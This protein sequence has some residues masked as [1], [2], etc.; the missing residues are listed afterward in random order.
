MLLLLLLLLIELPSSTIA[1]APAVAADQSTAAVAADCFKI[2]NMK[3][4]TFN[5]RRPMLLISSLLSV[6]I[7]KI[8]GVPPLL[9][10]KLATLCL[11]DCP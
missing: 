6:S 5:R 1:D 11:R 2:R 10:T 9:R 7:A 3:L 8:I 4:M